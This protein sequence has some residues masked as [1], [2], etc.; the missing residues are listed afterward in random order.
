MEAKVW[1]DLG[2]TDARRRRD[3]ALDGG[4]ELVRV[5]ADDLHEE[6]EAPGGDD[7]VVDRVQQR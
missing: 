1:K 7:D 5:A 6:L 2:L 4:Q 3:L